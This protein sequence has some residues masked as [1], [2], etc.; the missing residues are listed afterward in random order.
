[1][2]KLFWVV[3]QLG[4]QSMVTFIL[5]NLTC[6][7]SRLQSCPRK[8]CSETRRHTKPDLIIGFQGT[9]I[10]LK[11]HGNLVALV[12]DDLAYS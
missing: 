1:M 9:L 8:T 5:V 12:V 2:S 11:V 6:S 10:H 3:G 7:G 4:S